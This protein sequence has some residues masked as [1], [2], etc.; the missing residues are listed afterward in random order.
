MNTTKLLDGKDLGKKTA[1]FVKQKIKSDIFFGK[2]NIGTS[3]T[4]CIHTLEMNSTWWQYL[5]LIE[6]YLRT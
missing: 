2:E 1:L 3:S 4:T 6:K 5:M